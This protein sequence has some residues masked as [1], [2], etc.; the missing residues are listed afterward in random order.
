MTKWLWQLKW[1]L[2]IAIFAGPAFSYY[3]FNESKR[4]QRI[5]TD[6]VETTAAVDGG[7]VTRRRRG[8]ADYTLNVHWRDA[9]GAVHSQTLDISDAFAERI[10]VDDQVTIDQTRIKYLDPY[11]YDGVIVAE[12][13]PEQLANK[14][15][16]FWLG[17]LA[18]IAG[19]IV[20]P[21]MFWLERR[22]AKSQEADIDA[23]LARMRAGQSQ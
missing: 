6:G 1:A 12:D 19:L 3:S 15:F 23:T 5:I 11:R 9:K 21:I 17:I 14:T 10:I 20:S 22:Q 4:I 2:V 13:A 18:G 7:A 16:D 8:Q